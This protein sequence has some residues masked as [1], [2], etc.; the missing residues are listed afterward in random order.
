MPFALE[1]NSPNPFNPSTSIGFSLP[2][3]APVSLGIYD[4]SGKLV[5]N[6]IAGQV[7]GPGHLEKVWDGRNDS[8]RLVPTGVYFC[9]LTADG[10]VN[11]RRM[12]LVK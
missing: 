6:L 5:R 3:T 11:V 1:Q 7:M 9:K 4:L 12:A 8:G 10:R 2:T